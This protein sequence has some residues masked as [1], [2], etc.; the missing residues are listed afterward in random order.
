VRLD[1][2]DEGDDPYVLTNTVDARNATDAV[3]LAIVRFFLS[4]AEYDPDV[5]SPGGDSFFSASYIADVN[6]PQMSNIA[7][8]SQPLTLSFVR[9]RNCNLTT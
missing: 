8:L 9:G 4:T 6:S 2:L 5:V 3:S 7:G 1:I